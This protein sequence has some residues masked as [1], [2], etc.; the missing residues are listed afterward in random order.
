MRAALMTVGAS[1]VEELQKAV[2]AEIFA[3][4]ASG[5][6]Q[7]RRD[8]ELGGFELECR[9]KLLFRSLGLPVTDGPPNLHGICLAGLPAGLVP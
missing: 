7:F 3:L 8:C 6:L 5:E 4:L 9:V 2:D 1:S